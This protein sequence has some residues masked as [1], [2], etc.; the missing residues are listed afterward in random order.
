MSFIEQFY[1]VIR[2]GEVR[3]LSARLMHLGKQDPNF[4]SYF[5][6]NY[7]KD[8][9]LSVKLYFS[10]ISQP[11]KEAFDLFPVD[12]AVERMISLH[13]EPSDK[14]LKMHQGL[15]FGL[16]CYLKENTIRVNKYLHF[17]TSDFILGMPQLLPLKKEDLESSPGICIEFHPEANELKRYYYVCSDEGKRMIGDAF[18]ISALGP[19]K[20]SLVEYTESDR[21]SKINLVIPAASDVQKL[22]EIPAHP[23][24][25]EL[26]RHFY[27]NHQLYFF[28]PGIRKDQ[29]ARAIYFLPKEI[30]SGLKIIRLDDSLFG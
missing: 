12:E 4:C 30:Y 27:S 17:R 19:E 26:S 10:F 29:D 7:S 8:S 3:A 15:T 6:V 2:N 20:I 23:E 11:P 18:R 24:I 5:G 9:L 1:S 28:G 21:E 14:L 16:K 22:M 25:M 13:W